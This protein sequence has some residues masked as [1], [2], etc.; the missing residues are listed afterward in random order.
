M[1]ARY[2]RRALGSIA[3]NLRHKEFLR[4]LSKSGM[5]FDEAGHAVPT[6]FFEMYPETKGQVVP[7]GDVCFRVWNMDPLEHYCLAA[8]AAVREPQ[9]IFE[10][11]TFDGSSTL[12]LARTVPTATIY[13]LDLPDEAIERKLVKKAQLRASESFPSEPGGE[14]ITQLYGDSRVFDFSPYYDKMD[15][16]IVD[17]GHLADCVI[18]DTENALKMVAPGGMVVWDDYVPRFPDVVAA[19]DDAA[20]R[21]GL[22]VMR[23]LPTELAVYDSTKSPAGSSQT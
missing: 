21:K 8:I 2:W 17:G 4:E 11:G 6:S 12:L 1:T 19:V 5:K 16:V 18:P 14:R 13:T 15:L 3:R 9:N 7:M 10:I 23:L 22:F 20:K